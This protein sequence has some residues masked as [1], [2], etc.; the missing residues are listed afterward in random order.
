MSAYKAME[1]YGYDLNN[2][3]GYENVNEAKKVLDDPESIGDRFWVA[4]EE[5]VCKRGPRGELIFAYPEE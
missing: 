5:L 1:I 3:R 2:G 4:G